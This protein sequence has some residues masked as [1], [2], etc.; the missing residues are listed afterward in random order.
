[1]TA[2]LP[3]EDQEAARFHQWLDLKKLRHTHIANESR[4]GR[5]GMIRGAKLKGMGQSA[6]FPDF[7]ILIPKSDIER[8]IELTSDFRH[9]K[10]DGKFSHRPVAIELKRAKGGNTSAAQKEWLEDLLNA[11]V[12]STVCMGADAA[13][14]WVEE[15]L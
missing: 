2:P 10:L 3:T 13:I 15:R 14:K 1:M 7:I 8:M 6:G 4:S 12:E 11:G 5:Y 9:R